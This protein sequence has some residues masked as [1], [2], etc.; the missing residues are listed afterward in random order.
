[1]RVNP[2]D[3]H[4]VLLDKS[5]AYF[6]ICKHVRC[7][8]KLPHDNTRRCLA[9]ACD[10]TTETIA[11]RQVLDALRPV[12]RIMS[13]GPEEE[14]HSEAARSSNAT[15]SCEYIERNTLA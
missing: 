3:K 12:T 7:D 15:A 11:L 8:T 14:D 9:R 13:P 1:M 5:E 4:T 6:S 10:D 2:A